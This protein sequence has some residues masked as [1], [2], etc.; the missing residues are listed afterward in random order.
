MFFF[1]LALFLSV[2]GLVVLL[3]LYSTVHHVNGKSPPNPWD[4]YAI[5]NVLYG[6]DH[7]KGRLWFA[8]FF[9]YIFS[10]YFC[11]LLHAEYNHFSVKRLHYLVQVSYKSKHFALFYVN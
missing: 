6:S 4:D 7:E 9:A 10:A 3:P 1:R 8:A 11:R 5:S 2:W